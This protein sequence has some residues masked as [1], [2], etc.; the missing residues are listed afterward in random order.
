MKRRRTE[1]ERRIGAILGCMFFSGL[2]VWPLPGRADEPNSMTCDYCN[3]KIEEEAITDL[4]LYFQF[5]HT[6]LTFQKVDS[7]FAAETEIAV[8]LFDEQGEFV[9]EIFVDR[10][11]EE[12]D[13]DRTI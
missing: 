13:F 10:T 7:V 1:R 9:D 12:K 8:T 3:F 11:I 4:E 6:S 5:P 2:M